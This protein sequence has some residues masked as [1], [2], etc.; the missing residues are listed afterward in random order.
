MEAASFIESELGLSA[1]SASFIAMSSANVPIALLSGR[2]YTLVT[3]VESPHPRSHPNNFPGD[4]VSQNEWHPLGQDEFELAAADLGVEQVHTGRVD[5]DQH[6]A[7][8][9]HRFWHVGDPALIARFVAVDDEGLH[10]WIWRNE[11]TV[12]VG[13]SLHFTVLIG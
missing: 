7:V 10:G 3:D 1:T 4:V 13:T 6:L 2:A 9:G 12:R 8:G 11:L 5:L